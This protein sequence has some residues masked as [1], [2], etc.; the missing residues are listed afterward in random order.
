MSTDTISEKTTLTNIEPIKK[1]RGRPKK[2]NDVK[3]SA[4][5]IN[6]ND[7]VKKSR[8]RPKKSDMSREEYQKEYHKQYGP[9][10]YEKNRQKINEEHTYLSKKY[11][12][13]YKL[14][15]ELY[16]IDFQNIPK[17]LNEKIV[18]FF[19]SKQI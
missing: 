8:G 16:K 13:G 19:N 10:Y 1:S 4:E 3:T 9:Q 2:N 6:D 12:E 5:T 7:K 15:K 14:L 17:D 11:R 18:S